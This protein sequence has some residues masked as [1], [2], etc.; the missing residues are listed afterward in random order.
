MLLRVCCGCFG[1]GLAQSPLFD[2]QA[3]LTQASLLL[4][5][6]KKP[7]STR[8]RVTMKFDSWDPLR[9]SESL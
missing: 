2:S 9:G 8:T 4:S 5:A 6:K 7:V 3:T 1:R